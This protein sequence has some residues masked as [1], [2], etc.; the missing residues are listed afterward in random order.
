MSTDWTTLQSQAAVATRV[1]KALAS[2]TPKAVSGL[3][4]TDLSPL[5][6]LKPAL[7]R[8][9]AEYPSIENGL[10][11]T[12]QWALEAIHD[13]A[14]TPAEAFVAVEGRE[15]AP[16]QGDA[17]FYAIIR[18]LAR[19]PSPLIASPVDRFASL[20]DDRLAH[21]E[22]SLTSSADDVLGRRADWFR[23][24]GVSKWIGGVH[25]IGP[26]PKWR[27]DPGVGKVVG[28]D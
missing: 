28:S 7:E 15:P 9:L 4:K 12:E 24:Y 20:R 21:A 3:F 10:G 23:L 17:M 14:R 22:I 19:G 26:A 5:P 27:W 8:Y 25:F 11:Q 18:D 6:F 16:Y 13:G 2:P 1:W